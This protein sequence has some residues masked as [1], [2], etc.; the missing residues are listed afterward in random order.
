M[1]SPP[2][3]HPGNNKW[4]TFDEWNTMKQPSSIQVVK[5]EKETLQDSF[6]RFNLEQ[7]QDGWG[8]ASSAQDAGWGLPQTDD[9]W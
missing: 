9:G 2:P 5:S 3:H 1:S 7:D 8:D 4:Q 6:K